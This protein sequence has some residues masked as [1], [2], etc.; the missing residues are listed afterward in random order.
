MITPQEADELA[1][2]TIETYV[3][4]CNCMTSKDVGNVL[5]K[6]VSSAG[7][8]MKAVE[9]RE[10]AVDRLLSTAWY[11]KNYDIIKSA[12]KTTSH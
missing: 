7:L 11:V 6:L 9:G 2:K 8:S 1:K 10:V 3:N 5:M 12:P 4:A